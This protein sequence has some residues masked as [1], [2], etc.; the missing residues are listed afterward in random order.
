MQNRTSTIQVQ[1]FPTPMQDFM[2]QVHASEPMDVDFSQKVNEVSRWQ[3]LANCRGLDPDLFYP[4]RG[5]STQDAKRVCREC[6]VTQ[7]CLEYALQN[8]EK[9]GIWGGM[10]ERERREVR[11][12]RAMLRVP[13][14]GS[15]ASSA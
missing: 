6:V 4:N 7:E 9:L 1:D 14:S 11:R 10:S 13:Q 8:R 12:E 5:D 3:E 2:Q 15:A